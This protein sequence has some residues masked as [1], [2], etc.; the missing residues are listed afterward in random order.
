L[1]VCAAARG[2]VCRERVCRTIDGASS[3]A[4]S[5][6][7]CDRLVHDAYKVKLGNESIRKTKAD[8]TKGQK[9][10]KW[11]SRQKGVPG[12]AK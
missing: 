2:R 5:D 9:P 4:R 6:A 8:L 7:V 10:A 3:L 12:L 11:R 1:C